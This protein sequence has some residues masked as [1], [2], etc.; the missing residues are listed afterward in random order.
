MSRRRV[1]FVCAM[2]LAAGLWAAAHVPSTIRQGVN[3]QQHTITEPLFLKALDFIDRHQHYRLLARDITQGAGNDEERMLR[4]FQWAHE[5]IRPVPHGLPIM[6]DHIW[7]IIIRG[8]GT[9]DQV[10]D[11]F[12]TLCVYAGLPAFWQWVSVGGRAT[13]FAV[14]LVKLKGQWVVVDPFHQRLFR[15]P[16][17]ALASIEDLQADPGLAS[18][19]LEPLL[20]HGVPYERYFAALGPIREPRVLRAKLQVP[21]YRL[22]Y[23][24]SRRCGIGGFGA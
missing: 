20:V 11:V 10:N 16:D 21:L 9:A 22:W 1:A 7:H 12:T 8:Y 2:V 13:Q 18:R 14:S 3:F 15:R 4:L 24:V 23:E 5:H 17:G 19:G 6:D